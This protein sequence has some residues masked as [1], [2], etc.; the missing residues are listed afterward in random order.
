MNEEMKYEDRKKKGMNIV[1]EGRM[2]TEIRDR[3]LFLIM[4]IFQH[5][6]IL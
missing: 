3:I 5:C 1:V 2:E 4:Y 6:N